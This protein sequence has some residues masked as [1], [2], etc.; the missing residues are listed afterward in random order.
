MV[1]ITALASP[2]VTLRAQLR[3]SWLENQIFNKEADDV[4]F[5]WGAG[6]WETLE[7]Q[8]DSWSSA[9]VQ[10]ADEL[11]SG[12][13]PAWLIDNLSPF[14]ALS[15]VARA[16]LRQVI[17]ARYLRASHIAELRVPLRDA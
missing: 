11:E 4:A 15:E 7:A 9:A 17:H 10:L 3:H 14:S 13:S 1:V 2:A 5:L 12:F 8:F 6:F 16:Q